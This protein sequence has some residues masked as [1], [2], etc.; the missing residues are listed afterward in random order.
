MFHNT[1]GKNH[2]KGTR[3]SK[4]ASRVSESPYVYV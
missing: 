4:M 1:E 2:Y 3:H